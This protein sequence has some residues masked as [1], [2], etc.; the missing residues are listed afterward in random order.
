M[1]KMSIFRSTYSKRLRHRAPRETN[2]DI[3]IYCAHRPFPAD[4]AWFDQRRQLLKKY[5]PP[6]IGERHRMDQCDRIIG[7]NYLRI[8]WQAIYPLY[9]LREM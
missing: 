1:S 2:T 6:D 9:F 8:H 7:C 4:V 3:L 5:R